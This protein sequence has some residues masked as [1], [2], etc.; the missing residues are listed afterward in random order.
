MTAAAIR[1]PNLESETHFLESLLQKRSKLG[2]L[3]KLAQLMPKPHS[4]W[5]LKTFAAQDN[6]TVA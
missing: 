6:L 4:S 5:F 3:A 2:A 1:F